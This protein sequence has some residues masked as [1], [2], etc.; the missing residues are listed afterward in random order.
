MISVLLPKVKPLEAG[1]EQQYEYLL[2]V[3]MD[4]LYILSPDKTKIVETIVD[5]K[6]NDGYVCACENENA[7][8]DAIIDIK[9]YILAGH[10]PLAYI[11]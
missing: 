1:N 6:D 10:N 9:R 4:G 7:F 8:L 3:S 5:G 2:A 11:L